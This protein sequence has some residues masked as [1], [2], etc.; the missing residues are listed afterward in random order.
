MVRVSGEGARLSARACSC[1]SM[2][3]PAE[4]S[5]SIT[6]AKATSSLSCE[7]VRSRL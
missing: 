4:A 5:T 7:D 1:G 3:S 6:K 2:T